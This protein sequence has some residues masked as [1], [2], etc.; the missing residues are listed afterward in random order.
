ML[1]SGDADSEREAQ[2]YLIKLGSHRAGT[3]AWADDAA[4]RAATLAQ[5]LALRKSMAGGTTGMDAV[6]DSFSPATVSVPGKR[7][8]PLNLE[9]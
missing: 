5:L 3:L 2:R 8:A 7:P 6:I 4:V 1:A 9:Q